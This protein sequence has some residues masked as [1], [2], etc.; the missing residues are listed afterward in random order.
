MRFGEALKEAVKYHAMA[1]VPTLIGL[2]VVFGSLWIGIIDPF[3]GAIAGELGEPTVA[4]ERAFEAEYSLGIAL[5]GVVAGLLIRRI[6]RTALLFRTHGNAV[7]DVVDREVVPEELGES[8]ASADESTGGPS[9]RY[10]A[11]ASADSPGEESPE[12]DPDETPTDTAATDT[13]TAATDE[14]RGGEDDADACDDTEP[15][16]SDNKSDVDDDSDG[17]DTGGDDNE[18]DGEAD[19]VRDADADD[20]SGASDR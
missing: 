4:L 10:D 20:R 19:T 14:P 13:A 2:A 9:R 8:H 6:G 12:T 1:I 15:D 16:A 3:I 18:S 17:A 7:V 5:F 11:N